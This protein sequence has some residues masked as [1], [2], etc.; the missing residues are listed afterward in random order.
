MGLFADNSSQD[1]D[2]DKE[3]SDAA[4]FVEDE[5]IDAIAEFINGTSNESS[6]NGTGL[7]VQW[8]SVES[9]DSRCDMPSKELATPRWRSPMKGL[10]P[11]AAS[12][13]LK[14]TIEECMKVKDARKLKLE[15]KIIVP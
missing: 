5:T 7:D 14:E 10:G 11:T 3:S 1:I 13:G 6:T 15:G 4:R 9:S 12:L 2:V 8:N